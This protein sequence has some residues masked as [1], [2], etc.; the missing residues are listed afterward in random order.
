[1]MINGERMLIGV[2]LIL[3]FVAIIITF[4]KFSASRGSAATAYTM[5]LLAPT[6]ST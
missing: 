1:M 4:R 2:I 5:D 3:A 6:E